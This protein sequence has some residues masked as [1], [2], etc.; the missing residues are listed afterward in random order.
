MGLQV[1]VSA[2]KKEAKEL[3]RQMNLES[4]AIII[5][6]DDGFAFQE[7]EIDSG[8]NS[9][10][11]SIV[12]KKVKA[13]TFAERGVGLSRNN[14]LMRAEDEL[15]L[16]SD[17]DIVFD[18]G[19]AQIITRE[20]AAH[21]AA[22][23]IMFNVKVDKR[24]ATYENKAF[25]RVRWYNYGRYPA[26][27]IAARTDKIHAANVNFSL[28]FGGGA[29]YASGEDTLFLHDC[30]KKG[31]RLFASPQFIG[32]EVYRESTWFDGFTEKFFHD[33]GVMYRY[34]YGVMANP[35]AFR[36]LWSKRK[37]MCR[38]IKLRQAYHLMKEGIRK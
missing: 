5:I 27:S 23:L 26:Y 12:K 33:R 38:D 14:A 13:Y 21:P 37:E 24:R 35:L 10:D 28:L 16:F 36:F 1:L 25:H 7:F 22:D 29:K 8:I 34:L 3:A 32:C 20:F 9:D 18:H 6:Q 2:V 30:L 15:L 19:Y 31:L 4:N 11:G 17:E